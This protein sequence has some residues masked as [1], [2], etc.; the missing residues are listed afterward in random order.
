[1]NDSGLLC[2]NRRKV[3]RGGARLGGSFH[4]IFGGIRVDPFALFLPGESDAE[5]RRMRRIAK[6][7]TIPRHELQHRSGPAVLAVQHVDAQ[8]NDAL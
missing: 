6:R 7:D 5:G 1:M 2:L 8:W 3:D 4:T